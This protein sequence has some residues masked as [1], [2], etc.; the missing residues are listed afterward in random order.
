MSRIELQHLMF[1]Y[2]RQ[3]PE[4][5][6]KDLCMSVEDGQSVGIIGPNGVGKSTL[7]KILTGLLLEY[8]GK[9]C[10]DGFAVQKQNLDQI[11]KKLGY[12]F[13]DSDSQLFM[14]TVYEDVAL[15][16]LNYGMK[17]D[18]VKM[19]VEKALC[20]TRIENLADRQIYRLSGGEKKLVSIAGILA[21]GS[22]ILLMDEPSAALDPS[23][24]ENLIEIIR[25]L[26]GVKIIASHD[27]DF[28][29]DTCER[30][31]LL[32]GGRIAFD[33]DTKEVLRNRELLEANGLRLPLS[34]RFMN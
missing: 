16:P 22:D 19:R 32:S 7:L 1:R 33:G 3:Q 11:R 20:Q 6:L 24:R 30:T 26:K 31:V 28:I 13:Q 14:N 2:K 12:V 8:E 15:G 4:Y 25:D 17:E 21:I 10:V 34:F 27:L 23:N 29:Y 9:A 18:E 5:V